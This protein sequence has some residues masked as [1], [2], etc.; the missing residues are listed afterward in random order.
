MLP[1]TREDNSSQVYVEPARK[2]YRRKATDAGSII[3]L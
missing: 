1:G 3:K 2:H